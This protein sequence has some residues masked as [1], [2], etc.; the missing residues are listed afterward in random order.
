M[1]LPN[2]PFEGQ[3]WAYALQLYAEPGVSQSCL[4]LQEDR[5]VDVMLLLVVAFAGQ[6][7]IDLSPADIR[8]M[9][10]TCRPWHQQIVQPLRALRVALKSGPPPAPS[11]ATE[12]LRSQI[13]ASELHAER[14]QSDLLA[15]WLG[16]KARARGA[17]AA[18]K[19]QGALGDV[20]ALAMPNRDLTDRDLRALRCIAQ[21]A[22]RL[23]GAAPH[24]R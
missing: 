5:G 20:I 23:A 13:K 24:S 9:A 22:Q 16:R 10:A 3:C 17:V 7:G 4:E 12:T 18:D 21:A 8:E 2:A 15:S 11:G 19:R 14:L 1:T 6:S